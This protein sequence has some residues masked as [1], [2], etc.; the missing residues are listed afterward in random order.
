VNYPQPAEIADYFG[1]FSGVDL[2]DFGRLRSIFLQ[3]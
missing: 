3:N 2:Q 1:D